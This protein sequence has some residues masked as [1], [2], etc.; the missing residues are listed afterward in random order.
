MPR[1]GAPQRVDM[2]LGDQPTAIGGTRACFRVSPAAAGAGLGVFATQFIARG[3]LITW[4]AGTY[5]WNP[6]AEE[7]G[8]A[9]HVRTVL[10]GF[11]AIDGIREPV[12]GAGAGSFVN[13]ASRAARVNARYR[14]DDVALRVAIVATRDIAEGEEVLVTYGRDYWRRNNVV[15]IDL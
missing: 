3:S 15:P 14:V 6:R 9:S 2:D 5:L 13:A 8:T 1:G 11:L 10:H 12:H 4:Y 7:L